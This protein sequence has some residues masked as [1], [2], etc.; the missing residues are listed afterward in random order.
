MLC[1]YSCSL[2]RYLLRPRRSQSWDV[3]G[4]MSPCRL[5]ERKLPRSQ[6][7]GW[8]LSFIPSTFSGGSPTVFYRWGNWGPGRLHYLPR[9]T[10]FCVGHWDLSSVLS[11]SL[12]YRVIRPPH[13]YP[14]IPIPLKWSLNL[15]HNFLQV[16]TFLWSPKILTEWQI[17]VV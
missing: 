7:G 14:Q 12:C 1:L 4:K 2:H 8:V 17:W 10:Q 15:S 5:R 3:S 6:A 13:G 16:G 9:F 11:G